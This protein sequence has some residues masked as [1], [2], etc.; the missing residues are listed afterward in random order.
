MLST[1][2]RVYLSVKC[3]TFPFTG[4]HIHKTHRLSFAGQLKTHCRTAE[5]NCLITVF[6]LKNKRSD[7]EGVGRGVKF[8][9]KY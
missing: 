7:P 9:E 4:A 1:R 3:Q 2:E 6:R 5:K 8:T